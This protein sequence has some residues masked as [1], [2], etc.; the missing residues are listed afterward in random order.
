M[1]TRIRPLSRAQQR[2]SSPRAVPTPERLQIIS[3]VEDLFTL[4]DQ[5]EARLA[6]ARRVVDRLTPALLAKAFRGELV[7]QDP[8]DESASVLLERIRAAR[9]ADAAVSADS[10]N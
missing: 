7:P 9:Q 8:G 10:E 6:T 1:Q 3:R 2:W 5:L 4:A